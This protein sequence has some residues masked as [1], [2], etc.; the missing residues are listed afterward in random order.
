MLTLRLMKGSVKPIVVGVEGI[1]MNS[2]E[3][4]QKGLEKF[5]RC[6]PPLDD[7]LILDDP[8]YSAPLHDHSLKLEVVG[9]DGFMMNSGEIHRLGEE[10][11]EEL[12]GCERSVVN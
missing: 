1:G 11:R 5:H 8:Q 4:L 10:D 9:I 7:I 12:G 2:G 6:G 3:R